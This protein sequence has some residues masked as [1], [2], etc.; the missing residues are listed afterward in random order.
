MLT[1]E[2]LHVDLGEFTLDATLTVGTGRKVA[3]LGPSG[4]GKS[5]LLAAI[6]GFQPATGRIAWNDDSLAGRAPADRPITT[7]FQDNNLFPHL[8]A[9][10]NV[11]LGLRPDLR[12]T[13]ADETQV[14]EALARVGLDG[15]GPRK[16]ARLSGGQAARVALARALLR[17]KPVMLLDEPFGALG[18][19]LRDEM[20]GLVRDLADETGATLLMVSHEPEDARTIADEVILVADGRAHAP[21]PTAEIFANPPEALRDYLGR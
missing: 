14:E 21:V 20:L 4:A 10:Q 2:N 1:L 6:A 16:P 3:I 18:P 17:H 7:I 11:G 15:L 8:T 12:L 13:K 19:A 9:A 5:T